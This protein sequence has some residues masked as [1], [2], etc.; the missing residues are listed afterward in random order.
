M[1]ILG[2][3]LKSIFRGAAD[4]TVTV[5][6]S[7]HPAGYEEYGRRFI[8]TFEPRWPDN[9]RLRVYAEGFA[10]QPG[11]ARTTV[12][13]LLQAVPE[14]SEFRERF[15][16]KPQARGTM[17]DGGYNYRFD[18]V[19]FANKSF[20]TAHAARS[21][22][23]RFLVW[24]DADSVTLRTVPRDLVSSLIGEETFVAYFGREFKHTETGFLAFD[25]SRPNAAEFFDT[26]RKIYLSGEVFRL[27]EWHDCEVFDAARTVLSAQGRITSRNLSSGGTAH[28]I[29]NSVL[30]EYIDHL[31][32]PDRK[33][34]G[35][36]AARDRKFFR[37]RRLPPMPANL[38]AGRYAYIARLIEA[39]K[40]RSIVEIGT[41]SGH[42]ALQMA[43][44]ALKHSPA[45]TY[46]G[47]DLFETGNAAD[48]EREKNVKRHFDLDDVKAL[49]E[50]FALEN[51]G[52]GFSLVSGDTRRSLPETQ[53]DF[54]FIDGGH[55][56]ETIRS[57]YERL[58]ACKVIV[59]D[60]FYEG[61]IDTALY[62]CNAVVRNL[63]H[64]VLPQADPVAG[65]GVTR[66]VLVAEPQLLAQLESILQR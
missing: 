64:R 54:A 22:G 56:V 12:L 17:P 42:R 19:K 25:L 58:R 66:F 39:V 2:N 27:R 51:P 7:M 62:G 65:G 8:D 49:L 30:G 9:Y 37:G 47:F 50:S 31:K 15:G 43:R 63:P 20:A 46:T 45:V 32:G 48:D 11:S 18:A 35:A 33:K 55:S 53:A 38:D 36:S 26:V 52:F 5:T 28:P 10:L 40:P 24:L 34:A 4:Q 13:D 41:W 3:V 16:D 29:A 60:D 44:I 14:I 23:T 59:F 1:G 21:C 6:T 57:D 61:P